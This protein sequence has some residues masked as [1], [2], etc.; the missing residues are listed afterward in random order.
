M[1]YLAVSGSLDSFAQRLDQKVASIKETVAKIP[2]AS[3]PAPTAA[4]SSSG[5]S[6]L[7]LVGGLAAVAAG[8][9]WLWKRRKK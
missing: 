9:F 8:G 6:K 3:G 5:P 2:T 7:L 4:P 1:S